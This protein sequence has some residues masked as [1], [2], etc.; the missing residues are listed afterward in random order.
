MCE[1]GIGAQGVGQGH[2]SFGGDAVPS[3]AVEKKREG[4]ERKKA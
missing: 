3:K 1:G 4:G 2:G